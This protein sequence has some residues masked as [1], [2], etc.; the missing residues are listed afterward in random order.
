MKQL[1]K[2]K[3][4]PVARAP[5]FFLITVWGGVYIE[6]V[7]RNGHWTTHTGAGIREYSTLLGRAALYGQ[8][9]KQPKPSKT[10]QKQTKNKKN[11][12]KQ[13]KLI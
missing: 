4:N 9:P 12:Q 5:I 13:T 6:A 10:K 2:Y 3:K 1:H 8:I 7:E 11:K